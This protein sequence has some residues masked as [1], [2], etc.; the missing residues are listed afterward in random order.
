M[1]REKNDA[2]AHRHDFIA[3]ILHSHAQQCLSSLAQATANAPAAARAAPRLRLPGR[4][5]LAAV[6]EAAA[7]PTGPSMLL[8]LLRR[9]FALV[10][11][12]LLMPSKSAFRQ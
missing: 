2:V 6:G 12:P 3:I 7:A 9:L 10:A 5:A 11:F 8:G 1:S 4:P